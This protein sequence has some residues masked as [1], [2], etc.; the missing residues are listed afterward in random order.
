MN[1][2]YLIG[3]E[4]K[5]PYWAALLVGVMLGPCSLLIPAQLSWFALAAGICATAIL[6]W[7][8]VMMSPW[9]SSTAF[10]RTRPV[11][12]QQMF[13]VKSAAMSLLVIFPVVVA[14]GMIV[15][16]MDG[17]SRWL[18]VLM[19]L[20]GT[21]GVLALVATVSAIGTAGRQFAVI[22]WL[23]LTV[24][25][26]LSFGIWSYLRY[27]FRGELMPQT[28]E[29]AAF[30][31]MLAMMFLWMATGLV[32]WWLVGRN[33]NYRKATFVLLGAAIVLPA[34]FVVGVGILSAPTRPAAPR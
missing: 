10:W 7:L 18:F 16:S 21:V 19:S 1:V 14:V 2:S 5:Q 6:A 17:T 8:V 32:T 9:F 25:P 15:L 34:V 11:S 33:G 13:L 23:S 30:Y 20:M 27:K 3:R 29:S 12:R 26:M 31:W 28:S 4:V 22:G 24:L